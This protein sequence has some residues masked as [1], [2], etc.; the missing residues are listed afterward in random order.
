MSDNRAIGK[1]VGE[2]ILDYLTKQYPDIKQVAEA[3][4]LQSDTRDRMT[5]ILRVQPQMITPA[6][7]SQLYKP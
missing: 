1:L 4:W 7:A 2:F 3:K 6:N 5:E